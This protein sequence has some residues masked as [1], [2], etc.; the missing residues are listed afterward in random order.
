MKGYEYVMK[1]E[2]IF[3]AAVVSIALAGTFMVA[4]HAD[5]EGDNDA[6]VNQNAAVSYEF[7]L[8]DDEIY[9]SESTFGQMGDYTLTFYGVISGDFTE[10]HV[11][12]G[13]DDDTWGYEL[14]VDNSN[15]TI[16]D[17]QLSETLV[18]YEHGLSVAGHIDIEV[19]VDFDGTADISLNTS[20]GGTA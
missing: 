12:K 13:I 9:S 20:G 10:L 6:A 17:K 15:L 3:A 8:T 18:T 7:I 19:S 1:K 14:V 4:H 5:K 11:G 2:R 16:Y